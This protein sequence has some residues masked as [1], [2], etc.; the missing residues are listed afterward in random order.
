MIPLRGQ[1]PYPDAGLRCPTSPRSSNRLP[2]LQPNSTTLRYPAKRIVP[3]SPRLCSKAQTLTRYRK[4]PVPI[5]PLE[6]RIG[7]GQRKFEI[8]RRDQKCAGNIRDDAP[9]PVGNCH[10]PAL[11]APGPPGWKHNNTSSNAATLAS[12]LSL[13]V[14]R[15]G[16]VRTLSGPAA[17]GE[18]AND[19]RHDRADRELLLP[20]VIH[21]SGTP[22]FCY[23]Q[24]RRDSGPILQRSQP[25]HP[26][27][28]GTLAGLP[29]RE[30]RDDIDEAGRKL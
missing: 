29:T 7:P 2:I 20:W 18:S 30:G 16:T 5:E 27:G 28:I 4:P 1:Y 13:S 3:D 25:P 12:R 9:R 26:G 23:F 21:P 10:N 17:R 14:S 19:P 24:W 8:R 11:C 15:G 22:N 6:R